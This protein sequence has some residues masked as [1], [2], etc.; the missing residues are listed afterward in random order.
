[1]ET[2]PYTIP[3]EVDK[4]HFLYNSL[5]NALLEVDMSC[6]KLFDSRNNRDL[7]DLSEEKEL[8]D[9]LVD[10]QFVTSNLRSF[11]YLQNTHLLYQNN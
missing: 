6:Y 1:M 8:F 2:S 4:R 3:F 7:S 11:V 9:I 5:S 10:K